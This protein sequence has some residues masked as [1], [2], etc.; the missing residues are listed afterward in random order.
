VVGAGARVPGRGPTTRSVSKVAE[1]V[2]ENLIGAEKLDL[3]ILS[4]FIKFG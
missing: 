1:P 4:N 3:V 2:F